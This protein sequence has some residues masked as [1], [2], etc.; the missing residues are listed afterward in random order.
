MPFR[1][2]GNRPV[3]LITP[4]ITAY[5]IDNI[6]TTGFV[7]TDFTVTWSDVDVGDVLTM[8][9]T[10]NTLPSQFLF[11]VTSGMPTTTIIT[12]INVSLNAV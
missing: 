5:S 4:V 6:K 8:T 1:R 3:T 9:A 2:A 11:N 7:I 10:S 12:T